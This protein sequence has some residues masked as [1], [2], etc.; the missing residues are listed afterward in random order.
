MRAYHVTIAI[1][2]R[3]QRLTI[4]ADFFG[5]SEEDFVF[6][7]D[8]DAV[9]WVPAD[10]VVS[11]VPPK[12]FRIPD[13]GGEEKGGPNRLRDKSPPGG[14]VAFWATASPHFRDDEKLTNPKEP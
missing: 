6:W 1:L 11:I 14:F 7:I 5:L 3:T 4:R 8:A 12:N 10:I 2:Q 13:G 9:A